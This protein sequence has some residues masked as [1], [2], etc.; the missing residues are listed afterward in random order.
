MLFGSLLQVS[1]ADELV[2]MVCRVR[3]GRGVLHYGPDAAP[4]D[5]PADATADI[6]DASTNAPDAPANASDTPT[7]DANAAPDDSA[8]DTPANTT[9]SPTIRRLRSHRLSGRIWH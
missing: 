2:G 6:S 3:D 8:P 5:G 4:H 9:A 1:V 7:N